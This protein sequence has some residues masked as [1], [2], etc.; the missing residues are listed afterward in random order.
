M[1]F[2]PQCKGTDSDTLKDVDVKWYSIGDF[3]AHDCW[4]WSIKYDG[5]YAQIHI[6]E[7]GNVLFYTSS[8]KPY[9]NETLANDLVS[10][11]SDEFYPLVL[12]AEYLGNGEG[13]LGGR[14]AAAVVTTART[15]YAKGISYSAEHKIRIFDIICPFDG[16]KPPVRFKDRLEMLKDLQTYLDGSKYIACVEYFKCEKLEDAYTVRN[17][18]VGRGYEGVYVKN[19]CHVQRA[20]KRVKDALKFKIKNTTTLTIVGIDEG[21]GRF[22][23]LI[24]AF[25]CVDANGMNVNVGSGLSDEVR[26]LPRKSV[27]G[28]RIRINYE[29]VDQTYIFPIFID[30][31]E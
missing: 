16:D 23:D 29:R 13:K 9:V 3:I 1:E 27:I 15:A 28:K 25:I 14:N 6:D 24:G 22:K 18:I 30:F 7:A 31:C 8:G 19:T 2:I 21:T 17:K 5:Q 26:R 10:R 20:G 4:Y 11:I 12:E